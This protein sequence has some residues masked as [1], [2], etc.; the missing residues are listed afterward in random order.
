MLDGC[1]QNPHHFNEDT[2]CRAEFLFE[3]LSYALGKCRTQTRCTY[4]QCEGTSF[5][6]RWDY[7]GAQFRVGCQIA[8]YRPAPGRRR[9]FAVQSGIARCSKYQ[10]Y[11]F[12]MGWIIIFCNPVYAPPAQLVPQ[13][14]RE[15]P[16]HNSDSGSEGKKGPDLAFGYRSPANHK[17][18]PACERHEHGVV[19]ARSRSAAILQSVHDL[20]VRP[21][22]RFSTISFPPRQR[23]DAK[24]TGAK[25]GEERKYSYCCN[26]SHH[27]FT[28]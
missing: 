28:M 26:A 16:C 25:K 15:L 6:N 4:S 5:H 11:P 19:L 20:P 17:T 1:P 27:G 8:P 14:R 9:N 2:P 7:E 3:F 21:R 22:E 10:V 12:Q 23:R 18:Y 13:S 24:K